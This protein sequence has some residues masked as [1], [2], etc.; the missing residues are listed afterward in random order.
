MIEVLAARG[1]DPLAAEQSVI[2]ALEDETDAEREERVQAQA[3][4]ERRR[5]YQEQQAFLRQ[6]PGLRQA[7]VAGVGAYVRSGKRG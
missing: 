1:I 4:A 3:A 5:Q 2:E 7:G 6:A